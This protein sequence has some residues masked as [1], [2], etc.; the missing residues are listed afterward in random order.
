MKILTTAVTA[1]ALAF[2]AHGASAQDL[3][4]VPVAIGSGGNLEA[5]ITE[6]GKQGG[7]FEEYGLDPDIRYTR[8]GGETIQAVVSGGVEIGVAPGGVGVIS[9]FK[10]GAPIKVIGASTTGSANYWYVRED[11]E[12]Q[13][14]ED[15]AGHSVAYSTTGSGTYNIGKMLMEL[16]DLDF[17][18]VA[19][20]GTPA[21]FT[22]VMS[23]Q[24]DVGFSYPEFGTDAIDRGEIRVVF[25]DNDIDRIKNQS[26]RWIIA[27]SDASDDL[28]QRYMSAY[29]DTIDWIF[30]GSDEALEIY[31]KE[32]DVDLDRAK[33]L[34]DDFWSPEILTVDKVSGLDIITEDAIAQGVLEEPLSDEEQAKLFQYPE[35]IEK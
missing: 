16:Y 8:G 31:A 13:K 24:V 22:Q 1:A 21:T 34:R 35:R 29:Q 9:A 32:I 5:L 11:S 7:I 6:I 33:T 18:H 3:E 23:G 30:S 12:I 25:R 26:L 4:T 20:G 15:F 10:Q 14:I 17:D 27:N 2:A 19:T 28:V